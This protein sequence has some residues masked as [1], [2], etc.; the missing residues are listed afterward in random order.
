MLWLSKELSLIAVAIPTVWQYVGL[1][2]V[3]LLTAIMKIPKDYYE[4]A[5]L[6]GIVGI[7]RTMYITV[8]LIW[9]DFKICL[10]LAISGSFKVF[11]LVYIITKGGPLG[12]S[13]V[14]GTYMY[15]ATFVMENIGYGASIGI[16]IVILGVGLSLLINRLL[17]R[18]E[19]TY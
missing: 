18:D 13:E 1:Y 6:E 4:A 15:K 7:K 11:E 14:L 5:E 12:S 2:F 8:P 19:I 10:I 16:Y 17:K 3:I 9:S